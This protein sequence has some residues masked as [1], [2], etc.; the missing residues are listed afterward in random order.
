MLEFD[1][2]IQYKQGK[3]NVVAD[4]LSRVEGSE[5]LH[6]AMTVIECDLLKQ[7]HEA[8]ER[9]A[10]LKNIIEELKQKL[11]SKKHYSW[12]QDIL[13]RKNKIVVPAETELREMIMSWLH[14]SSHAGHSG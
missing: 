3:H 6:M 10:V 13:R 9:D 11:R 8:Y 12:Y 14:G 2:E 4:A 5:I 1:Y 7:I